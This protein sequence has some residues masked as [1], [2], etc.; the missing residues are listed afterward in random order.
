MGRTKADELTALAETLAKWLEP[1]SGFKAYLFGSRVRGD[2]RRD[3]D[4][5]VRIFLE[6]CKPDAAG[7]RWWTDQNQTDFAAVKAQLPGP[8]K[9]HRDTPGDADRHIRAGAKN[10]VMTIGRLVVVADPAE[11]I[12]ADSIRDA[13]TGNGQG[14]KNP[15]KL[16]SRRG[17]AR[18]LATTS[19]TLKNP[20][21]NYK[22]CARVSEGPGDY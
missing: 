18:E 10:P 21:H 20:F 11:V 5:D 3:S 8:L 13:R 19:G 12:L 7:T 1:A 6:D 2:H 15:A 14:A 9:I 22:L 4:V 17:R 16:H